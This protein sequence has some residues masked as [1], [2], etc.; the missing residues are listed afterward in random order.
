MP[1]QSSVSTTGPASIE[2][3]ETQGV[4]R[5]HAIPFEEVLTR[6]QTDR[7]GL[8]EAEGAKRREASGLNVLREG[9]K[10]TL[11]RRFLEQS[12]MS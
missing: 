2:K 4:A 8:T 6:Q 11:L 9:R 10:K 1:E 3:A 5:W 12:P 7:N